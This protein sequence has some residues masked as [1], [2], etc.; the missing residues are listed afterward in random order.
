MHVQGGLEGTGELAGLGGRQRESAVRT[1]T[2]REAGERILGLSLTTRLT[3][4]NYVKPTSKANA[5]SPQPQKGSV[6]AMT[7][8]GSGSEITL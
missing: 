1:Q 6:Q 3:G 7:S 2:L 8:G 4:V 5:F